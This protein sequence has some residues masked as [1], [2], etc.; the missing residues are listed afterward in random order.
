M[1]NV[2]IIDVDTSHA[3]VLGNYVNATGRARVTLVH[4][5]GDVW[6]R[7]YAVALAEQLGG[8]YTDDPDE[9]VARCDLVLYL[10]A[11]YHERLERARPAIQAGKAVF[12]DKPAVASMAQIRELNE[13]L[14]SGARIMMGSSLTYCPELREARELVGSDHPTSLIVFGSQEYYTHGIHAADIALDLLG[15]RA[16]SV[17]WSSFGPCEILWVT[18]PTPIPL[19]LVLS[20]PGHQW[21]LVATGATKGCFTALNADY[22]PE[23]HYARLASALVEFARTGTCTVRPQTHVEAIRLLAAGAVSR[24]TGQTQFVDDV[25]ET[26]GFDGQAYLEWY[27]NRSVGKSISDYLSPSRHVLSGEPLHAEVSRPRARRT[28][29]TVAR[30]LLG[31][32]C[33]G[34]LRLLLRGS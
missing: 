8:R 11:A 34:A 14:R 28:L 6:P 23:C 7:G 29:R 13:C 3:W 19:G 33:Y 21:F 18:S 16:E 15:D 10:G 30:R 31:E 24:E 9:V 22:G 20:R 4:D 5:H 17:T 27:R 2:G 32:R 1:T 26:F 25:P 12:L